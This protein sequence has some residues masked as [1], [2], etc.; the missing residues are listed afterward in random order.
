MVDEKWQASVATRLAIAAMCVV[1]L[2]QIVM[3][4]FLSSGDTPEEMDSGEWRLAAVGVSALQL[5]LLVGALWRT[6][7]RITHSVAGPAWVL[8]KAIDAMCEGKFD[9]RLTLR[10]GDALKSLAAAIQR[11]RTQMQRQQGG[12]PAGAPA[13]DEPEGVEAAPTL[14]TTGAETKHNSEPSLATGRPGTKPGQEGFTLVDTLLASAL[15]I[16]GT[17]G[18]ASMAVYCSNL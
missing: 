15:L 10:R 18:A 16:V 12:A 7:I 14:V 13:A 6:S 2:T 1:A 17:L 3:I 8:E 4:F 11:L 9:S 5:I